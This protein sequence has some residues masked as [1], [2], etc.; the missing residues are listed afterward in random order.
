[1]NSIEA[2]KANIEHEKNIL[3]EALT[4]SNYL[5]LLE[6]LEKKGYRINERERRLLNNAIYSLMQQLKILNNSVPEIIKRISIFEELP[7][8]KP[9]EKK[10]LERVK[11]KKQE[12]LVSLKY[13]PVV[14]SQ[15]EG[16]DSFITIKKEDKLRFLRELSLT[17]SSLRKI[18]RDYSA[19]GK[20][21]EQ[22]R[23]PSLYAKISNRFFSKW[24]NQLIDKGHFSKLRGEL[25]K[26]NMPFLLHTYIS[27]AFFTTVLSVFAAILILVVLLFFNVGIGFPFFALTK[28]S[29]LLRLA[30]YFWLIFAIPAAMFFAFY[31]YPS[32][33]KKSI[34]KKINQELPFIVIHMSAIASSGVEPSNIFKIIVLG[35]EYPATKK[36]LKKLLNQ[37]NLYGYDLVTAL[38]NSAR[39][40]SSNKLA[41]LFNGLAT[42]ITSG[43]SLNEFLDKRAETLVF[44]YRLEREKYTHMAE[45]FMNIYIS[46]VIAAPMILTMLLVMITLTGMGFGLS[47]NAVSLLMVL[48][49]AV[50]NIVFL[51]FLHLKQPRF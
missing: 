4:F 23:K 18:K 14:S 7:T 43:G 41:E 45:T 32:T 49:I 9:A 34:A 46:V 2:L 44:D 36:E 13:K 3:R 19:L 33:E 28:E 50:I 39:L 20:R 24:S 42:T 38:R 15:K 12:N 37:I 40:T 51:V 30:K 1:M 16:V 10:E 48:G 6:N 17:D 11:S 47:M 35:E 29:I 5:E 8:E 26:A 21:A 22:F 25:R 31:F 27:M